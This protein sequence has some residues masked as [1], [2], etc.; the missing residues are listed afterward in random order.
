[1]LSYETETANTTVTLF[2]ACSGEVQKGISTTF[3]LATFQ[4][5]IAS[6]VMRAQLRA[7]PKPSVHYDNIVHKSLMRALNWVSM[8]PRSMNLS[9]D[10]W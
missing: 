10:R 9:D 1:M 8:M 5:S 7:F 4:E 3:R 2:G 6:D